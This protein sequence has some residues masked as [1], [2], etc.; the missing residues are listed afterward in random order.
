MNDTARSLV[1]LIGHEGEDWVEYD[2]EALELNYTT[3]HNN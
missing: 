3:I 2:S 1:V